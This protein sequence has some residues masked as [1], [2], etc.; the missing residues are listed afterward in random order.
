[1]SERFNDSSDAAKE[2]RR[3]EELAASAPHQ[4][5]VQQA[6]AQELTNVRGAFAA[7]LADLKRATLK[8]DGTVPGRDAYD[9]CHLRV[10]KAAERL[11]AITGQGVSMPA[12]IP[13]PAATEA[14]TVTVAPPAA[15]LGAYRE[16]KG[17]G[18]SGAGLP[19]TG[20]GSN[21]DPDWTTT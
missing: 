7:G 13:P 15:D 6:L 12:W 11:A 5:G 16:T 3:R 10:T 9:R 21:T 4:R 18:A 1:M 17:M 19:L 2:Q 14:D 8:R 20:P